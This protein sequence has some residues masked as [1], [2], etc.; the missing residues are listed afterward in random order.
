MPT[1]NR[2][3]FG[4]V[5][6]GAT[7][8]IVSTLLAGSVL[9]QSAADFA[10]RNA[11]NTPPTGWDGPVF[12]LSH[13]YPSEHPG[14]C[15]K[16]V[17]TWLDVDVD[18][19]VDFSEDGIPDYYEGNWHEYIMRIMAYVAEGQDPS[20][21]NETGFATNIGGRDVWFHV[22]WMAYDPTQGR[23]FVHGTTNERTAHVADFVGDGNPNTSM[24]ANLASGGCEE[25]FPH[26]FESWAVG[27]YNVWGGWA[28]GQAFPSDGQPAIDEYLGSAVA[29]G[30]PFPEGT[31]VAKFLTTNAPVDC[32]DYLAGS[33]EWQVNRHKVN[34][35]G[36]YSC[37]REVA[38]TRLIQVDVAVVDLRAPT[39]WVY[40]TFGYRAEGP[41]TGLPG[42][43]GRLIP[44]GVQWGSD[45]WTFPA[46][47][48]SESI[49]ARQS[50][51]NPDIGIFEHEGCMDRLAGPVDNPMSSCM[52]CHGSSFA[53]PDRQV[54]MMGVNVPPT[55][56]FDGIC[57]QFSQ[58]NQNYFQN[59]TV[60]QKYRGGQFPDAISLDTSLQ[61]AVAFT[62]NGYFNTDGKPVA[63]K[64]PNQ[65]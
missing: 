43:F 61:L 33:P 6:F 36:S 63:C 5:A 62:Q 21:S 16:E 13:Q 54:S 44:I 57:T 47:P 58:D 26:G 45:P 55:F 59:I 14:E 20:L 27:V 46:V 18:F 51:L 28:I 9:A 23:E 29:K 25:R 53:A 52:S 30:L 37:E 40:G 2:G 4:A 42:T 17:C 8:S 31:V 22:P 64:D 1:I 39:R 24:N 38:I 3:R 19:S 60:P 65:F 15:P 12:E 34:D 11:V 32:V 48:Q 41:E 10:F 49:P 7:I 35:D 50:V 56:G